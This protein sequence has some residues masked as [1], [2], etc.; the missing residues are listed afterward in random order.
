[1][2]LND[3]AV[4]ALQRQKAHTFLEGGHVFHDLKTGK[5]WKYRT[6]T[7]VRGFWEITLKQ[8]GIRYRRPYNMR[9]TYATIGLMS[10]AKPGFL[11]DQLG[12]SLRMFFDVYAKWLRSVDDQL[13]VAKVD[14]AI[15]QQFQ[16]NSTARKIDE[17]DEPNG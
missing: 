7:D 10:G 2:L 6:I 17:T 1:M 14:S 8:L 3:M 16:N 12:H 9:H 13:E 5:P 4:D 11:A 15:K